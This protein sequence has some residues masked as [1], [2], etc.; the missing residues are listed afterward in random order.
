MTQPSPPDAATPAPGAVSVVRRWF[1]DGVLRRIFRNAGTLLGGKAV[2]AVLAL[3]SLA[4]TARGLGPEL[5]GRGGEQQQARDLRGELFHALVA[6]AA[7]FWAPVQVMRFIDNYK[8][9]SRGKFRK[10]LQTRPAPQPLEGTYGV[11][12]G[13]PAVSFKTLQEVIK[14]G[15]I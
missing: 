13:L 5:F 4:V 11:V 7:A 12:T 15:A 2:S 9:E 10:T 3:A 1:D 14:I 8:I 6:G